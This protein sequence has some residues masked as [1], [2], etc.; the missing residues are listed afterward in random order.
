MVRPDIQ[1]AAHCHS[2]YGKAW[3]VF[4]KPMEITVT[5]RLM[6]T[7]Q[8]PHGVRELWR[9]RVGK[10]G[11]G[12]YCSGTGTQVEDVHLAN[13]GLVTREIALLFSFFPLRFG[14][15]VVGSTVDEAAALFNKL[16]R[17]C[18]VMLM[19][20]FAGHGLKPTVISKEE[21]E[22]SAKL[23]QD[24]HF[25]YATVS[26]WRCSQVDYSDDIHYLVSTRIYSP[27]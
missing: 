23:P 27:P 24:P 4:G 10:G 1:A 8:Q 21:A 20:S 15:C 9:D 25:T 14:L 7:S 11:R 5:P 3:S 6:R 19:T 16:D 18:H 26:D 17:Q 13:Y 2:M 22:N 12:K